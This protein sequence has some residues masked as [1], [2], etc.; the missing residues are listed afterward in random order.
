VRAERLL[1]A[2]GRRPATDG[3]GAEA[4]GVALGP[5]GEVVVDARLATGAEG[6]FAAG[7]VTGHAQ[8]THLADE[9]GRL[10]ARNA[11]ARRGRAL[12]LAAIPSVVFTDPEVARVGVAEADAPGRARVAEVAMSGVDRAATEGREEGFARLVA[13]P[14][15]L[16][17]RRWGGRLVGAT[18]VCPRAGELIHEP[19]L[20]IRSGMF[21]GRLAQTVHA[22]PTWSTAIRQ[23]AAQLVDAPG[24]PR[25]RRPRGEPGRAGG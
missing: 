13:V 20:A 9:M 24:A 17:G 22:Y 11:F 7:D 16:L 23:A 25:A 2:T 21:A 5:D 14:R 6:V 12:A 15:P 8:L 18:I 3:L 1:V 19:A 10:A 4:A